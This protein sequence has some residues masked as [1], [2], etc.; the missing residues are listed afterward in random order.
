MD[1]SNLVGRANEIADIARSLADELARRELSEP[2]FEHGLPD[3]L[4][5]D[6]PESDALTARFKLLA[7]VDELHDLLTEPA[8]LGSPELVS[9]GISFP[10]PG[11]SS[12]S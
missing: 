2:S 8:L 11:P 5:S 9:P 12:F 10:P 3:P 7:V 4:H 1:R 6:A